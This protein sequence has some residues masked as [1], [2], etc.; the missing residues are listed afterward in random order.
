M[1]IFVLS[2]LHLVEP[3]G[4]QYILILWFGR[5]LLIN[6]LCFTHLKKKNVI[7]CISQ[8]NRTSNQNNRCIFQW[9]LQPSQQ[10]ELAGDGGFKTLE[11]EAQAYNRPLQNKD[12]GFCRKIQRQIG[13][14]STHFYNN[15]GQT[16]FYSYW[17]IGPRNTKIQAP[18]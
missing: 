6:T 12:H 8:Q 1:M 9:S 17:A 14:E 4:S 2:L 7:Y 5:F 16:H 15:Q 13:Q 3:F 11:E 10:G 18:L